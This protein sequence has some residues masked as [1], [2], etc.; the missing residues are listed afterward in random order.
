MWVGGNTSPWLADWLISKKG[1]S[2]TLVR[3]G[4]SITALTVSAAFIVAAA[5]A[6]CDRVLVITLF[7]LAMTI[8]GTAYPSVMVNALDLSPNYAGT[9]NT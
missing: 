9:L 1:V 6:G 5:Y 7:V 3:K 8:M 4:G 2:I